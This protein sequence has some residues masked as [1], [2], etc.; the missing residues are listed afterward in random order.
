[1][2]N[3]VFNMSFYRHYPDK[4]LTAGMIVL[5]GYL[6]YH[7]VAHRR[8]TQVGL[9]LMCHTT[10]DRCYD[11]NFLRF[12]TIN[13]RFFKNQCYDQICENTSSS[14]SKKRQ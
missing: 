3:F 5:K 7:K 9:I 11:H 8:T 2:A 6:L 4:L 1:M 13:S 10:R 14:L 12:S